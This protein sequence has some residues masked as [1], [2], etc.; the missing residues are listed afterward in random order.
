M[1]TA[2]TARMPIKVVN[3]S[4]SNI[5][6]GFERI[7]ALVLGDWISALGLCQAWWLPGTTMGVATR[8]PERVGRPFIQS[9]NVP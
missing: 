7:L 5:L 6:G 1:F 9:N 8:R 4:R 3:E 2:S